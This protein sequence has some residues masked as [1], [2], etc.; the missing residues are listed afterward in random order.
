MAPAV[1]RIGE[2][3]QLA[4]LVADDAVVRDQR[5]AA[6]RRRR[7]RP[8]CCRRPRSAARRRRG[9]RGDRRPRRR[10]WRAARD[11]AAR[12][13]RPARVARGAPAKRRHGRAAASA[14]PG[15]GPARR[16]PG[17]R[18]RPASQRARPGVAAHSSPGI[19]TQTPP[20][21]QPRR[22]GAT[23]PRADRHGEQ[24]CPGRRRVDVELGRQR[25]A[26]RP[27]PS[28]ACR[29]SSSRRAGAARRPPCPAP[30][31][32]PAL[33]PRVPSLARRAQQD[34]RRRRACLTQ[35][36][37]RL[38]RPRSPTLPASV[39]SKPEPRGQRAARRRR[40]SRDAALASSSTRR[41]PASGVRSLPSRDRDPRALA[42]ARVDRR[43]RS[44]AAWRRR[45]R[46]PG[47]CR[48]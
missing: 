40:A 23:A 15:R 41:R 16:P 36:R 48:S 21:S 18:H 8:R 32:A 31:R 12:A 43:T 47:R 10:A 35:V 34:A 39:S 4:H 20:I 2:L 45:G 27:G 11:A 29:R 17:R 5:C 46:G 22:V 37:R 14:A 9:R 1:Q 24:P 33:E 3:L 38:G 7:R 30:C 28:P 19:G 25:A 44:T 26:S 13:A 42:G 6:A